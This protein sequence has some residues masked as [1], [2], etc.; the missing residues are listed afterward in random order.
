MLSPPSKS[1]EHNW[2]ANLYGNI[3]HSSFEPKHGYHFDRPYS[4][5]VHTHFPGASQA[6]PSL[7]FMIHEDPLSPIFLTRSPPKA[8]VAGRHTLGRFEFSQNA[9]VG[10]SS[11]QCGS[12]LLAGNKARKDRFQPPLRAPALP[13]RSLSFLRSPS[14]T[15]FTWFKTCCF[16]V[17]PLQ[18]SGRYGGE[19]MTASCA[20]ISTLCQRMGM[21]L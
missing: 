9:A 15:L 3:S 13:A 2:K 11:R 1:R 4:H 6:R 12:L 16:D 14:R 8:P 20:I 7:A 19:M 17:E 5:L 21:L 18:S 10:L